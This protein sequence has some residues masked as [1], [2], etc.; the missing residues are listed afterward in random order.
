M[1]SKPSKGRELGEGLDTHG[2]AGVQEDNS[3]IARLDELGIVF[4]RLS[5]TAVNL[6]LDLSKLASNMRCVAIQHWA[7]SIGHLSRVVQHDDLCSEVRDSGCWLVLGVRGDISSLDILDR[8]V[9]DVEPNIVSGCGFWEGLVVHFHGLHLSGQLVG[10]ESDDHAGLD[11]SSLDTTH[12]DC[13]NASNFVNILKGQSE[14]LVCRSCWWNDGVKSFKKSGTAANIG[15]DLQLLSNLVPSSHFHLVNTK[16]V[17]CAAHPVGADRLVPDQGVGSLGG[18]KLLL[19]ELLS[20]HHALVL[21]EHL[22]HHEVLVLFVVHDLGVPGSVG[23]A[24]ANL[25]A[26][27]FVEDRHWVHVEVAL[28]VHVEHVGIVDQVN[29][30]VELGEGGSAA[31]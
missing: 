19:L 23:E 1:H 27:E 11:D 5:S 7:V 24:L 22:A 26:E 21:E 31:S 28:H 25:P 16:E 29:F 12:W 13:S 17:P 15:L 30:M 4:G 2:L 6:L 14:R 20:I 9:L 18:V 3:S 10:G 8:H